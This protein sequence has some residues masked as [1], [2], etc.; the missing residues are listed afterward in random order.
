[1]GSDVA[2]CLKVGVVNAIGEITPP[3]DRGSDGRV[4]RMKNVEHK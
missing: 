2:Q 4:R 1:M 3:L